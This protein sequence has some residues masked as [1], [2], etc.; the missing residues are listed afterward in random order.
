MPLAI[1][2]A[3]HIAMQEPRGPVFVSVPVDDWDRPCEPLPPRRVSTA[4]DADPAL[5]DEV[6][7]M[8][9]RSRSPAIVAG[10]GVAR[11]QAREA[12]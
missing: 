10:A 2:R 7:G 11:S 5:L 4:V 1:A 8:L 3:Y 6:G 12:L 9:A